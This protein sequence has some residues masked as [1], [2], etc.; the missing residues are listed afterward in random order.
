MATGSSLIHVLKRAAA[1][2]STSLLS[3][4]APTLLYK[5]APTASF[6][7]GSDTSRRMFNGGSDDQHDKDGMYICFEIPKLKKTKLHAAFVSV[8]QNT[9][10]VKEKSSGREIKRILINHDFHGLNG[11]KGEMENG[12]FNLWL[13]LP[14]LLT[15]QNGEQ[16]NHDDQGITTHECEGGCHAQVKMHPGMENDHYKLWVVQNK[17]IIKEQRSEGESASAIADLPPK[18]HSLNGA[19]GEMKYGVLSLWL[20]K[21]A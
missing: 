14:G 8:E 10:S 4:L 17:M 13:P 2:I 9:V 6:N 19:E 16:K 20:P 1:T 12:M 7:G 5:L 21:K 15:R 18:L 3:K 11:A